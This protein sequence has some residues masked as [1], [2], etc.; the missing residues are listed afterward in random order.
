MKK[1]FILF[2]VALIFISGCQPWA[3]TEAKK[4]EIT[5]SAA[6][7]LSESL[8]EIQKAFEK[9]NSSI[10]LS[11]NFGGSGS[12]RRQIEQGAPIDIYISA[13]KK[14]Y[15]LLEDQGMITS[16]TEILENQLIMI[17]TDD[18]S[19]FED[20]MNSDLKIS[21]GT[22]QAVPAGSY[23]KEALEQMGLWELLNDRL[24]YAKDVQ[25]VLT[26][27]KNGAV[28]AGIV[29]KSD[30]H[31]IEGIT[32]L[33]EIDPELHTPIEYYIGIINQNNRNQKEQEVVYHFLQNESS[34]RIFEKNGF[35]ISS[36]LIE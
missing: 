15:Q 28:K 34:L 32:V 18:S 16:G 23:A 21:I 24:V 8:F 7:S 29:Y 2:V 17:T 19:T 33:K 11:I 22:P 26:Y 36:E 25:Q 12:L 5:I 1:S 31:H 35:I 10:K 14:D 20:L 9:E 3:D 4:T 30:I 6:S 13:S 27:V